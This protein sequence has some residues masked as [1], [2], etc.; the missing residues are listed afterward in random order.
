TCLLILPRFY[1]QLG[2]L[3]SMPISDLIASLIAGGMLWWQ[4]R[5]FRKAT[6]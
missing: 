5:Q 2:V 6:A 3:I 4:F 1:G